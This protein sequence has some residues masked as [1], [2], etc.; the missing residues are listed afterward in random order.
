MRISPSPSDPNDPNTPLYQL[1][2]GTSNLI[3]NS[4]RIAYVA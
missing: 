4:Y 3:K 1:G 2:F